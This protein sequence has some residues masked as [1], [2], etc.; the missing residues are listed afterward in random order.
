MLLKLGVG[1]GLQFAHV[2]DLPD[3]WV[4]FLRTRGKLYTPDVRLVE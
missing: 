3:F 2:L 1:E 4:R